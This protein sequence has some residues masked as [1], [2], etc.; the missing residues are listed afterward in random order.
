M[1]AAVL[2]EI[3]GLRRFIAARAIRAAS[4]GRRTGIVTKKVEPVPSCDRSSSLPPS[5]F[6][7]R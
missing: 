6:T 3:E 1:K 5:A 2:K 4:P 7:P